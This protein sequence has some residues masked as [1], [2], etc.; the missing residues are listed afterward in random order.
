LSSRY[1]A[2]RFEDVSAN[3]FWRRG[4]GGE[5]KLADDPVRRGDPVA[6][7]FVVR[8][9]DEQHARVGDAA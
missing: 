1:L 6:S 2:A 7:P 5:L 4:A 3:A 8:V 9:E